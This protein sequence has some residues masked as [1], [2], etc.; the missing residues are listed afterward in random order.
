[1]SMI[2]GITQYYWNFFEYLDYQ[3]FDARIKMNDP[4]IKKNRSECVIFFYWDVDDRNETRSYAE[5][6]V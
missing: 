3:N 5:K 1:M 2:V 4:V 6:W